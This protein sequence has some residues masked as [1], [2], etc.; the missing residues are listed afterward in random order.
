MPF[1]SGVTLHEISLLPVWLFHR[2][3]NFRYPLKMPEL[4]WL[5]LLEVGI[6]YGL[7]SQERLQE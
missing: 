1:D 2:I 5:G 7:E 3:R 4:D 6:L